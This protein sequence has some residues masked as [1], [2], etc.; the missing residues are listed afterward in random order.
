MARIVQPSA[1]DNRSSRFCH[2]LP[3]PGEFT[4]FVR[5]HLPEPETCVRYAN[6]LSHA[7]RPSVQCWMAQDLAYEDSN[8]VLPDGEAHNAEFP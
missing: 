1:N 5:S 6:D 4:F 2:R 3:L 7:L 8:L